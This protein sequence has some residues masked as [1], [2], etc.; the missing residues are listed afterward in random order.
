[1]RPQ[2]RL[3]G[4]G[5]ALFWAMV[6]TAAAHLPVMASATATFDADGAYSVDLTFDVPPF[7]LDLLPQ[8]ATDPAMNSWLDGPTNAIAASLD[9]ARARFRSEF[10]VLGDGLPGKVDS[11]IF[12]TADDVVRY[13]ENAPTLRLPAMLMLS[14]TGRLPAG[15]RSVSFRFPAE[16]GV[17]A[18]NVIRPGLPPAA[19]VADSGAATTPLPLINTNGGAAGPATV[20]AAPEPGRWLVAKEYLGLGFKHIVPEGTDHILFVLGLFLLGNRL[21]PLLW[22]VTAF[23][24][25]HS[26]TLGLSL[27]G[28]FRLS[29]LVVEPLIAL[30]IAFVAVENIC[31]PELKPWRPFVVFG[32]G[33]MHGLG[34]AGVLTSLGL[35]R[36]DFAT[37]LVTFNAGV[38]LGQL[39][40]ITLAFLLVGWWRK[41]PWYRQAIVIPASVAIAGTGLFWT[42][43]RVAL[44]FR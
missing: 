42:V 26:I 3:L 27:Y 39:A 12:P 44:A 31:T 14:L 9:Q 11:L 8:K 21:R 22:Q 7:A 40:V 18:L 43:Q 2:L 33:L 23:T 19:L 16:M 41:K 4:A 25:A 20:A 15:A 36:R 24:V 28:I 30:S 34:F 38:E 5:L 13:R 29:P 10:A 17:V 37:A 32:F 35:P 1:M 6:F